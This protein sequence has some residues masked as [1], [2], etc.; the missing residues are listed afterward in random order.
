MKKIAI[1]QTSVILASFAS[2]VAASFAWFNL[3]EEVDISGGHGYTA[4]SYFHSGDGSEDDPYTITQPIHLYN[5]AWLQ[6]LGE[7]N[8]DNEQFHFQLLSDVDMSGLVLPPIGTVENPFIGTFDGDKYTISN[9]VVSNKIGQGENEISKKPLKVEASTFTG[10]NIVGMFGVVGDYNGAGTYS[11]F[12]PSISDVYL[13]GCTIAPQAGQ[14]LAGVAAGYVNGEMSGVGVNNSGLKIASGTTSLSSITTN[15]SDYT[16]VGYCTDNYINRLNI[17]DNLVY[18]P[19]RSTD[20]YNFEGDGGDMAGWGG[21]IDMKSMYDRLTTFNNNATNIS[22]NNPYVTKRTYSYYDDGS[23]TSVTNTNGTGISRYSST[24]KGK[25]VFRNNK[26]ANS[27]YWYLYGG[28]YDV[29]NNY[30]RVSSNITGITLSF[31]SNR[32]TMYLTTNGTSLT[33]T[34]NVNDASLWVLSN[35]NGSGTYQTYIGSELYYLYCNNNGGNITLSKTSQRNFSSANNYVSYTSGKNTYYLRYADSALSFNTST[36]NR[37]T[38][39]KGTSTTRTVYDDTL[40]SSEE[41]K[42]NEEY[43]CLP[44][45]VDKNNDVTPNNTGYITSGSYTTQSENGDVRVSR[46]ARNKL[47]NSV[48]NNNYSN[49][50]ILTRTYLSSGYK[51]ISDTFNKSNGA[52]DNSN[53]LRSYSKVGYE[54][55]GLDK[56]ESSRKSFG[57]VLQSDNSYVYGLHFMNSTIGM[58]NLIDATNITVNGDPTY[59][60]YQMPADAIDF[61]LKEPGKIN[62]FAGTYFTLNNQDN[63]NFFSLHQIFRNGTQISDIKEITNVY[64]DGVSNH[65][66]I[67]K[68]KDSSGNVSYSEGYSFDR[69]AG[70]KEYFGNTGLPSGYSEL[71]NTSWI[72]NPTMVMNAV[73]YFEIPMNEGEFALGACN[74]GSGAYLLYLDISANAQRVTS[75]VF[76]EEYKS[77]T[78]TYVCPYGVALVTPGSDVDNTNSIVSIAVAPSFSGPLSLSLNETI[79]TY[80]ASNTGITIGFVS[81]GTHLRKKNSSTDETAVPESTL[82]VITRKTTV[83]DINTVTGDQTITTLTQTTTNGVA[84]TAPVTVTRKNQDDEEMELEDYNISYFQNKYSDLGFVNLSSSDVVL[85][86]NVVYLDPTVASVQIELLLK[87]EDDA[88]DDLPYKVIDSYSIV[89]EIADGDGPINITVEEKDDEYVVSINGQEVSNGS[90]VSVVK[91]ILEP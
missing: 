3:K 79:A 25:V 52:L 62:F 63:S 18:S 16:L 54:D 15:I 42:N 76:R 45:N 83:V 51:R 50:E 31:T 75:T 84:A 88:S 7:F 57:N 30:H 34:T 81:E 4:A 53:P 33:T 40:L 73:Y 38:L 6:Y 13:D 5:L 20:V 9:L 91:A 14:I 77:L 19:T 32:T 35:Q 39:T 1:L 43:T 23:A 12:A 66:Y 67:Y 64:G 61:N 85:K 22:N 24:T 68:Y 17:S 48:Y 36:N 78:K 59:S 82:E 28:R 49:L 74:T 80:D 47:S 21:S 27:A 11:S 69:K 89:V 71:F 56:Y 87:T 60:S 58:D 70:T 86:Y 2:F 41:I 90:N 8:K 72:T 37:V 55:L 44:L 46:Y 65:S 26:G 10:V 29:H